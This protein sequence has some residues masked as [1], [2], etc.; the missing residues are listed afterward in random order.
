M[1]K[2]KPSSFNEKTL[3]NRLLKN[4]ALILVTLILIGMVSI[5]MNTYWQSMGRGEITAQEAVDTIARSINDKNIQGKTMLNGLTDNQEKINNLNRYMDEPISNYLNYSY[6]QQ[7]ATGNYLFLPGQVKNFY[8]MYDNIESI[9]MVLNNYNDYYL[10][11][12]D[13][14]SGK[15]ISG[16]PRLNNKFYLSY[17]ITNPVTLEVLG[18][19]YVEFSQKDIIDSLTH[20]TT[21]DGLSAYVF[22][23]TGYQL[24]TYT[25]KNNTLDQQ[26]IQQKM[27][28]IS[29]L[30]I[31]TLA[32][33]NLL[34][35]IQTTSGFDILVTVS[36]HQILTHVFF[37]LRILMIGGLGLIL[38]LLYL[39]YRTFTKYSQQVDIIMDSMALVTKGDLNTRINEQET[40]FELRELS[41]GIN[42]MLDNIEQ[43][44]ADI[45]KLEIKQQ[46][47]HMRA[48]QSQISPHFLYNTLEYI[49]M[50]AL[51][52]GSE[53]LADVVYA[54]STLLRNNTDQAKTTTLEKELSFCEKYVYL[55]QMRYPDRIAY[56]FEID[57]ALKKLVLPKFSIQPLIENYF[58]H[59]I[60]FSRND[61]A[62]S[63]KAHLSNDQVKILIRDNGKGISPQ[64]L[65]L[66]ET[67]LQS[68]Q[69]ELH[70]SI[71]LQN[72][73]ERLRA[74]FG[75]SFLMTIRPNETKG[76]AIELSFD[77]S[78][79]KTEIGYNNSQTSSQ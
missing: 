6:D 55:Y 13:D 57:D 62:I 25:E 67:K 41:K 69:I 3:L 59:G 53:E 49:R 22:S 50:Y 10:S 18:S 43:Y 2:K 64:K 44:I 16:T 79:P 20:L 21:F 29:L 52:E 45:Y 72:V 5:G 60:D 76:I 58:V 48:L 40:Q 38:L 65:A 68:E 73:N 28:E 7:L 71:G 30:P 17:P 37:D 11:T 61:N 74:Y 35:H 31:Q 14:K 36:K 54:F 63:V 47:A 46:D 8:T 75:P 70:G 27:K 23:S 1:R 66:I 32:Q 42:T 12:A 26:L 78:F 34:E 4:Y 9:I 39:L 56:H 77:D 19:F 24:L 51:S 33:T 15:K